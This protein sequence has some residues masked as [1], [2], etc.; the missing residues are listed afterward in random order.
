MHPDTRLRG[1][2]LGVKRVSYELRDAV[3]VTSLIAY[4]GVTNLPKLC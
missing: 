4:G 2:N 1:V 3:P